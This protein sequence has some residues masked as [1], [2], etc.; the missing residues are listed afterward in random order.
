MAAVGF[1]IVFASIAVMGQQRQEGRGLRPRPSEHVVL[2]THPSGGVVPS[3]RIE[4][5]TA[6]GSREVFTEIIETPDLD[7]RFRPSVET[8]TE[9][10]RS[11]SDAAQIKRDVYGFGASGERLLVETTRSEQVTLPDG[12]TTIVQDTWAPDINGR[13]AL[14][15]RQI[16][17][18]QPVARDN[19]A[20]SREVFHA[21]VNGDLRQSEV[22]RETE[23]QVGTDGVRRDSTFL[24]R[25][26][27][28][29]LQ[30]TEMRT[31]EVRTTGLEYVEEETIRRLD[32]NGDLV[33]SERNVVR[34]SQSNGEDRSVIETFSRN[35]GG[36]IESR[37]RLQ[38]TQRVRGTTKPASDGGSQTVEEV[39]ERVPG[40]PS[41]PVRVVRRTVETVR[42]IDAQHWES[43]LRVFDLDLNGRLVLT[44]EEKGAAT[45]GGSIRD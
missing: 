12:T 14:T 21:G 35:V 4:I 28:G 20:A 40:S 42:R 7:G 25:D 6:D 36:M 22:I 24:V 1:W 30:P 10:V 37:G 45:D 27:N 8:I 16:H 3:R 43:D 18:I 11:A 32:V 15:S 19:R 9:T 26:V 44:A 33:L 38:L 17:H 34:R 39:E 23:R 2:V 41:E 5:R 29:R 13:L 31:Q